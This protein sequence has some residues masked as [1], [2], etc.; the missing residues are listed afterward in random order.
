MMKR[1]ILLAKNSKGENVCIDDVPNGKK[2]NCVCVECG[3]K[4]VAKQGNIRAHHFAHENG[5]E[6]E[7][8]AQTALHLLAKS[9]IFDEGLIPKING[10]LQLEFA[11]AYK[12]EIEKNLGDIIPDVFAL[13]YDEK[14]VAV[15]I[16]VTHAVDEEKYKKIR[17][18]KLTTFEIDLSKI[19]YETKDDVKDAI[20][21]NLIYDENLEN[22]Q[23][24]L[25]KNL[26][27]Q[28]RQIIRK[29]GFTKTVANGRVSKCPMKCE[30][31]GTQLIKMFDV[32]FSKCKI[33]PFSYIP[34]N[35]SEFYCLGNI[36]G[37]EKIPI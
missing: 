37:K 22:Q 21:I 25:F 7:K 5:N 8:C 3:G 15:E 4:L 6:S 31:F 18:R 28:K 36:N 19:S 23:N 16:L 27:E 12:I 11:R 24:Q 30:I 9:I 2:C 33:C 20:N 17:K 14:E 13:Y 29:N 35:S 1:Y 10:K 26:I 32:S 34:K